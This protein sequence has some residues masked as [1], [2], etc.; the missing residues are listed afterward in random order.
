MTN[1]KAK[2]EVWKGFENLYGTHNPFNPLHSEFVDTILELR[3]RVETLEA[4]SSA[5]L[6]SSNYPPKQDSSLL[7][8][9]TKVIAPYTRDYRLIKFQPEA[10]AVILEIA[11]WMRTNPDYHFPPELVFAL[12]QEA[13]Q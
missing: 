11:T 13:E 7:E 10:R 2:P 5:P 12:E 9:V 8:K 4:N 6:T 1:Y 3:S